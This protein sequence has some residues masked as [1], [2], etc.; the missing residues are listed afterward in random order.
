MIIKVLRNNK[1]KSACANSVNIFNTHA[2]LLYLHSRLVD[3]C[4][5]G[6]TYS[7]NAVAMVKNRIAAPTDQVC[8]SLNDPYQVCVFRQVCM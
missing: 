8:T 7:V 6:S 3:I 1:T 5:Q 4:R 2:L